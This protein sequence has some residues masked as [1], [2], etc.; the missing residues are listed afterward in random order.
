MDERKLSELFNDAVRDV[1]PPSFDQ[2]DI[3]AESSRL[4]RKRNTLLTG[5]ALGFALLAGVIVAGDAW[6]P[7][8]TTGDS[9][10]AGSAE[11][12]AGGNDLSPQYEVTSDG[13][14]QK[15]AEAQD[16]PPATPSRGRSSDGNAGSQ[17]GGTPSGC[18]TADRELAAALAG[19]L[20][21]ATSRGEYVP[22]PLGCP[23]GG[24]SASFGVQDGPHRGLVSIMLVP[25]GVTAPLQPPWG[26]RPGAAGAVVATA[27]GAQLIVAVE[28]LPDSA[29]LPL[30]DGDVR[31][32]AQ[33]LAARY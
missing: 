16:F 23:A 9:S 2:S 7:S 8:Q 13:P 6:W 14:S 24:R 10:A 3:S 1:P 26:D 27:S 15:A 25:A 21:A 5:T 12:P 20:P 4:T 17:A 32:L 22:S 33:E 29:E 19:E 30:D 11:S 18:G 31:E 28:P